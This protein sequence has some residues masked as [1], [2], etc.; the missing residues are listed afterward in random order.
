MLS[1]ITMVSVTSISTRLE[2][3][4]AASICALSSTAKPGDVS[5]T[6]E[7][8]MLT[9]VPGFALR[10]AQTF[11]R[12]RRASGRMRP[13]A[14][15]TRMKSAG[16]DA[17]QR[18]TVPPGQSLELDDPAGE[19]GVHDRLVFDEE[20]RA[21]RPARSA[22]PSRSSCLSASLASIRMS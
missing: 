11:S 13:V 10:S 17:P 12:S 16:D 18:R 20:L 2:S 1:P 5:W 8:L 3:S 4:P 22:A 15:A 6:G 9:E 19:T 14:S 21:G 7:T